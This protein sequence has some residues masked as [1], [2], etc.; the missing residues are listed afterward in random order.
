[1]SGQFLNFLVL[2]FPREGNTELR[3]FLYI[4]KSFHTYID[5]LLY[6]FKHCCFS[7]QSFKCAFDLTDFLHARLRNQSWAT[8]MFLTASTHNIYC[9]KAY[10]NCGACYVCFHASVSCM[11]AQ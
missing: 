2:A 7:C 5:V 6:K 11:R 3:K 4:N 1:M 8:S 9:I 10:E